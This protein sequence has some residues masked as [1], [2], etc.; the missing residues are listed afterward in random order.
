LTDEVSQEDRIRMLKR[1]HQLSDKAGIPVTKIGI[2]DPM[3]L[4]IPD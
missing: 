4:N 3:A 1:Q 2:S